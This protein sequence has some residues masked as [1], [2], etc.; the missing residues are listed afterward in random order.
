MTLGTDNIFHVF[1]RPAL[2]T[3][4][5]RIFTLGL[6]E[7]YDAFKVQFILFR[8]AY[9]FVFYSHHF[10]TTI[11]N[12]F[13]CLFRNIFNRGIHREVV[14]QPY[15]FEL[16]EHP[17]FLVFSDWRN[18]ALSDGLLR[19]R[20]QLSLVHLFRSSESVTHGACALRAVE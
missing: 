15:N 7:V 16:I 17:I 5:F 14:F 4:A 1:V 9:S 18:P 8:D 20:K 3:S 11:E 12:D 19:I 2:Y 13:Q 10:I 6:D